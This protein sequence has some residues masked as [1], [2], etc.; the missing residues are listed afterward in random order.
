[1]KVITRTVTE[2][3]GENLGPVNWTYDFASHFLNVCSP[4]EVRDELCE[5]AKACLR[6]L[7][8]AALIGE[9]GKWKVVTTF[10]LDQPVEV[11]MYDGYPFWRP[12]PSYAIYTRGY[13]VI[14]HSF[15]D[16]SEIRKVVP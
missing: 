13:G 6:T 3:V 9:I 12:V 10:G 16:L 5:R 14:W 7:E 1:M 4:Q 8:D 11:G 15:D 2:R